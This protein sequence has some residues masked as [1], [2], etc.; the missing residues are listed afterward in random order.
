MSG[1]LNAQRFEKK[2]GETH[3]V[4]VDRLLHLGDST[5]MI[6]VLMIKDIMIHSVVDIQLFLGGL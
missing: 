5:E 6:L 4:L 1:K 3:R 2:P